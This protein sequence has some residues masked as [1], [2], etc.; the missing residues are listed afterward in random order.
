LA[1]SPRLAPRSPRQRSAITNSPFRLPGI[2]MRSTAGRRFVD[3]VDAA[4]AQF[5]ASN[6]EAIRELAGLKFTLEQ[7]QAAVVAGD[8]RAKEDMVRIARLI[9]RREATMRQAAAASKT[10]APNFADYI[11]ARYPSSEAGQ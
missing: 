9:D 7:T 3:L 6:T 4:L 1:P 2:D 10:K 11:A 5:G 8:A